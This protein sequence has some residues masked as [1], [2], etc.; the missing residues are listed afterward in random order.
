LDLN[1]SAFVVSLT[2]SY[3]RDIDSKQYGIIRHF[4]LHEQVLEGDFHHIDRKVN[5]MYF[6]INDFANMTLN[7]GWGENTKITK[8]IIDYYIKN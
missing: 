8:K 6:E 3:R 1:N 2:L 4:I 7:E 5:Y